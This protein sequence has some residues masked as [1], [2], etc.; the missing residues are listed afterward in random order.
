MIQANLAIVDIAS[1]SKSELAAFHLKYLPTPFIG[2]AGLKLLE[3]YYDALSQMDDAFG[4]V[5]MVDGHT[6]GFACAIHRQK[7]ILRALLARSPGSL[8]RWLCMQLLRKPHILGNLV[9]R[10]ATSPADDEHWQRPAEW[11]EWYTYRPLV[12]D[13]AFRQHRLADALTQSVLAEAQRRGVPGLISFVGRGN[14]SARVIHVRHGFREVWKAKDRTVFVR[15]LGT[16]RPREPRTSANPKLPI[17]TG[18][19]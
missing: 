12:V 11:S 9:G 14:S 19:S 2:Q 1:I 13:E 10:L 4:W 7:D 8:L 3:L 15:E 16:P 17:P 5:A 6:A 18:A